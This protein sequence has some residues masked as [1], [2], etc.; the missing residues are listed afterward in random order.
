M[1]HIGPHRIFELSQLE[2]EEITTQMTEWEMEH[3]R[4]CEEC[5]RILAVFAR[6]FDADRPPRDRPA[7]G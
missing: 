2:P 4:H 6:Q 1:N 7:Q 3:L 5:Q